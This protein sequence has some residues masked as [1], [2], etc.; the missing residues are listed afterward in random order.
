M[1]KFLAFL[2]TFALLLVPFST[3]SFAAEAYQDVTITGT[4]AEV[5]TVDGDKWNLYLN[6]SG[7]E[8]STWD[9]KYEGFTYEYNDVEFTVDFVQSTDIEN[10]LYCQIPTSVL[11]A[12]GGTI[13][14]KAGQLEPITGNTTTGIN[15]VSDIEIAAVDG[16]LAYVDKVIDTSNITIVNSISGA[17]GIYFTITDLEGNRINTDYTGWDG[18]YLCPAR[19]NGDTYTLADFNNTYSGVFQ[20]GL[21][22][23]TEKAKQDGFKN[24]DITDAAYYIGYLNAVAGTTVTL[25]GLMA[26]LSTSSWTSVATYY[27]KEVT[28]TY[29][30]STWSAVKTPEYSPITLAGVST[31]PSGFS[32]DNLVAYLYTNGYRGNA[33]WKYKYE[34]LTYEYN[35]VTGTTT[36]VS[37]AGTNVIYFTIP[38]SAVPAINGQIIT[39]K[40]GNYDADNEDI[41]NIATYGL[42]ITEDFELI[43]HD[44]EILAPTVIDDTN[45]EIIHNESSANALRFDLKDAN[46]VPTST[47]FEGWN[48]FLVPSTSL[49]Y[50]MEPESWATTYSGVY[51][52]GQ[53][54]NFAGWGLSNEISF[55]NV[56]AGAYYIG[57]ENFNAVKGTTITVRGYFVASSS[58]PGWAIM[59]TL[60]LNELTFTYDGT[61]WSL[62]REID[63]T[64]HTGTIVSSIPVDDGSFYFN[65]D[66]TDTFP[67]T[68]WNTEI[69]PLNDEAS[70]IYINGELTNAFLKKIDATSWYVCI[71]DVGLSLENNNVVTISG[72]FVYGT[73]KIT[74]GDYDYTYV[75]APTVNTYTG[76]PVLKESDEYG[77][78]ISFYFTSEDGAPHDSTWQEKITAAAGDDNGVFVNGTKTNII[79]KKINANTWFVDIAYDTQVSLNTDDVITIKGDFVYPN[80]DI[81]TFTETDFQFLGEHFAQGR[82]DITEFEILGLY[83]PHFAYNDAEERWD[84]YFRLNAE[85][86]GKEDLI[87]F[88]YLNYEIDGVEYAAHWYKSSTTFFDGEN[89]Y[90]NLYIPMPQLPKDLDKEYV[91]TLRAGTGQGRINGTE[92]A[93]SCAIR[94][95]KDYQF[96]I[97]GDY[98]ASAPAVDY[99]VG[100]G[101]TEN[102]IYL[103][104]TDDFPVTGWENK[105]V[106]FGAEDGVYVNG[107]LTNV[108]IK[109]YDNGKYYVCLVDEGHAAQEGTIVM[110]K[111]T[112]AD[113]QGLN[114][115]TFQTAKYIFTNGKWETFSAFVE[116]PSTGVSGD[117]NSDSKFNI[118]DLI[119]MKK[120]A[121]GIVDKINMVDADLNGDGKIN[122]NDIVLATKMSLGIVRFENGANIT[123]V[124]TYADDD[125][126]RLSA[127][128]SPTI[129]E[130]FDDYKAAGFTTLISEKIAAYG[131][132]KFDEYMNLAAEKG[133]DVIVHSDELNAMLL[134]LNAM[135]QNLLQAISNDLAKYNNFRGLLMSDEPTINHLNS[136]TQVTNVLK[137]LN[138]NIDF[139]TSCL[140]TYVS[141]ESLISTNNS[142]SFDEKYSAYANAYGNLFGDFTYDFYPFKHSYKQ[143]LSYKYDEK[144]YMRS[145]WFK[146]LTLAAANAKGKYTTGITVQS[147][148]EAINAK[149]HYRAVT[150]ADVSFQVYSALAYGM[151]SINYFTYGEHWDPNVGT[152]SSMIYNG[153]KTDIYYAVQSVNNEI[154]AFDNVLLNFNWQ[155]TIGI[156]GT[157]NDKIMNYVD[158]Y[159]SKRISN[160]TAS[161]DAIIGCLK[162]SKG[163]DGFMLVNSTDPSDNVTET[164]SVTFKNAD[165]AKVYIDGVENIVELSN[166]TFSATLA[167]GQGIF[168]IPYIA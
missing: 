90:H 141:D 70:G 88:V 39:I 165:H 4:W 140:P 149:D 115:V 100:N 167:P 138:P 69:H 49:G 161:N 36:Q 112:F 89:L 114:T 144:D 41:Q 77:S 48:K 83:Y 122:S 9:Y 76:T 98:K 32:G 66:E 105:V 26:T 160:A 80:G 42:N 43:I 139:L 28:F 21:S 157:N 64:E 97:G 1:K 136:Y 11:P 17:S 123:G 116:Q 18:Q 124:P 91:I 85:I 107:V 95:T 121:L 60:Y 86:P 145:D 120:V 109:K 132:D 130:G 153:Q 51:L 16:C 61:A 57:D 125:E 102:G 142:L 15:I 154:K 53:P 93:Q 33:Q 58:E 5:S 159:S 2:L 143:I 31:D 40:A 75:V 84:M 135:D 119:R 62:A 162:D 99:L 12:E 150:K 13:T 151:K 52:D 68:G 59:G 22:I 6:T 147:Y 94:L 65:T 101:G 137:L 37:S 72:A 45:V 50:R 106:K 46:G 7:Y 74:F 103:A 146:N 164:I 82:V 81:V 38:A 163:Y 67:V 118:M 78:N 24:P 133:L 87:H 156:T 131:S 158:A 134:G 30:G 47:G 129:E 168:V 126:M 127:Y 25:R 19:P 110:L 29:D 117:A 148:S 34:G 111:G 166:G 152:T 155:G 23:F 44:N 20:D 73:D 35:G 63:Y 96:V 113:E 27:F 8:S 92:E 54:M 10:K 55:K 128:V 56:G 14:I 104:V 108:F 3:L 79:L 71:K